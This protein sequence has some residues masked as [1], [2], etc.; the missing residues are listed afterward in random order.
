[1]PYLSMLT[2][3]KIL[4]VGGSFVYL[5]GVLNSSDLAIQIVF[6]TFIVIVGLMSPFM[7]K[8]CFDPLPTTNLLAT[9]SSG[10][11][12]YTTLFKVFAGIIIGYDNFKS[13][14]Y[15][16]ILIGILFLLVLIRLMEFKSISYHNHP[17]NAM[18]GIYLAI[19]TTISMTALVLLI[20]KQV[21][22]HSDSVAFT[23]I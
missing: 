20:I 23:Y 7:A 14:I 19:L 18:E 3:T 6:S 9:R 17:A 4:S 16:W 8:F 5:S 10:A 1:M 15:C 12:F 2:F 21:E 11:Q 22:S 13:S